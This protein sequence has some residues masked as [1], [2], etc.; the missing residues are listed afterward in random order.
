MHLGLGCVVAHGVRQ[1]GIRVFLYLMIA[2]GLS[3]RLFIEPPL[4]VFVV[5]GSCFLSQ[6]NAVGIVGE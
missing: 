3:V 2:F 1:L 4:K 5:Y 6:P